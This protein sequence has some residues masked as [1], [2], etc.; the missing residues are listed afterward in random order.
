MAI[1]GTIVLEDHWQ[2][3]LEFEVVNNEIVE[4]RPFQGFLW[5]GR[6]IRNDTVK[7]GD[8]LVLSIPGNENYVLKY[9]VKFFLKAVNNEDELLPLP[10]GIHP[11]ILA[12]AGLKD[13][14]K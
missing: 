2:D 13:E 6:K 7:K 4:T 9:P 11:A 10:G 1:N 5:N 12:A 8:R 14:E 3:F